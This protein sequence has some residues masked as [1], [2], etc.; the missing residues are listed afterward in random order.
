[1]A[2]RNGSNQ[3]ILLP[4]MMTQ[5]S[6]WGTNAAAR[7]ASAELPFAQPRRSSTTTSLPPDV[8]YSR[9]TRINRDIL[10]F[11][12]SPHPPNSTGPP[13]V[14]GIGVYTHAEVTAPA[15]KPLYPHQRFAAPET[16]TGFLPAGG[17]SRTERRR[18]MVGDLPDE[19]R[20]VYGELKRAL[21][22]EEKYAATHAGYDP[23]ERFD[24]LGVPED[25][26]KGRNAD[27]DTDMGGMDGKS[28]LVEGREGLHGEGRVEERGGSL[29]PVQA[30]K[31]L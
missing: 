5:N 17:P 7:R 27:G 25:G 22:D 3:D 19:V 18:A 8:A 14:R 24:V 11:F 15:Q 13:C 9:K 16:K 2:D 28:S 10:S 12:Q 29:L 23:R 6:M 30:E 21:D 26:V 31:E 1:M 20:Q 4:P